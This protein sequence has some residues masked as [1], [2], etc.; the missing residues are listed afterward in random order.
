MLSEKT[1][2]LGFSVLTSALIARY[3]GPKD[4]GELN[5]Y[6]ALLAIFIVVSSVGLNRIIVRDVVQSKDNKTQQNIITT[7]LYIRLFFLLHYIMGCIIFI[8][9]SLWR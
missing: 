8:I 9:I 2:R 4:F 6:I 7:A 3:L 1:I 5:Y